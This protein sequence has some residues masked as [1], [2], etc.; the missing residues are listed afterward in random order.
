VNNKVSFWASSKWSG[1]GAIATLVGLA[2]TATGLW[3]SV[4][5]ANPKDSTGTLHIQRF[6]A[7]SILPP[8]YFPNADQAPVRLSMG[9]LSALPGHLQLRTY[10]VQ[11]LSGRHLTTAD[12]DTPITVRALGGR[13]FVEVDVVPPANRPP[14]RVKVTADTA[15]IPPMLLNVGE[16]ALI[17]VLIQTS[18]VVPLLAEP[19]ANDDGVLAWT[20]Q[21]KGFDLS[22]TG[23]DRNQVSWLNSNV[24]GIFVIH[25]GYAVFAMVA[26]G[27]LLSLLQLGAM[28]WR[29]G[30]IILSFV[31]S[32]EISLRI[33]LAWG[34]AEVLV[35]FAD[36]QLSTYFWVN[37]FVLA[38][39]GM[40]LLPVHL[41]F[42]R[43]AAHKPAPQNPATE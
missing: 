35:T 15:T 37:W 32:V 13:K 24:P 22:V 25:T 34:A 26:I 16:V 43:K 4:H 1:I 3:L 30:K 6:I 18:D 20:A 19:Y 11:N 41:L 27:V 17:K 7:S 39:Y 33:A 2:L 36:T 29:R 9:G 5:L 40:L 28:A 12:F 31:R 21:I 23:A 8:E 42:R 10:L 38:I 14:I